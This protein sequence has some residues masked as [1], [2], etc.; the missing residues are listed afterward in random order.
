MAKSSSKSKSKPKTK[1]K[2]TPKSASPE[3][4]LVLTGLL[5]TALGVVS[6]LGLFSSQSS[7]ILSKIRSLILMGFGWGSYLLPLM[8]LGGGLLILLRKMEGAPSFSL[9]QIAGLVILYLAGLASLQYFTFPLDFKASKIIASG[10]L[11]GGYTGAYLLAPLQSTFGSAGTAIALV[12]VILLSLSLT[13]NIPVLD[14]F[15]WVPGFVRSLKNLFQ[16]L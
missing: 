11:G 9:E 3:Q 1:T 10:G 13:I 7:T 5:L 16:K 6:A 14:L 12:G 4:N 15:R 2:N 8:L